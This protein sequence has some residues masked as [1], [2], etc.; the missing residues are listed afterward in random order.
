MKIFFGA[1]GFILLLAT[2]LFFTGVI[3]KGCGK[4]V[5]AT[6]IDDAV[7]VYEEFQSIYNTCTKLNTDLGNMQAAP[8]DDAMFAQFSKAQRVLQIKTQL[9]R[10]VEEYNGKSK[11]WGRELWKS[12]TLPHDLNVNDFPNY[13]K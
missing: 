10:W 2:M 6:H 5:E 9:N 1:F 12:K 7:Q 13:S 4:A 11:M 8:A 3:G